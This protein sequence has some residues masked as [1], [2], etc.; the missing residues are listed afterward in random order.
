MAPRRTSQREVCPAKTRKL[1]GEPISVI[2]GQVV[3][4]EIVLSVWK[5]DGENL[6]S[7]RE[8]VRKREIY[9]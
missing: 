3:P 2:Q 8:R 6:I 9:T 4:N 1:R 5:E 7:E